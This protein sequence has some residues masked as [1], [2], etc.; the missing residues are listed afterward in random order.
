MRCVPA[1]GPLA[2]F[3]LGAALALATSAAAAPGERRPFPPAGLPTPNAVCYG[4]HR[5]GQRPG[6]AEPTAAQLRQ[7]ARLLRDHWPLLRIYGA[8]GFAPTLLDVLRQEGGRPLVV[9]GVWIAPDDSTANRAEIE[10]AVR[11]AAAY[12][13]L[14]VAVC[15]GNETQVS[16]SAHRCEPAVL[17]AALREVRARVAV[18]VT[19]ADDF[20]FWNKPESAA[21]AAEI[22]FILLHAHPLWNGRQCDEALPWLQ[23]QLADAQARHAGVPVFIGETGWATRRHTEGEQ[24]TLMKGVLGEPEQARFHA[25][26]R[27]WA[28]SVGVTTFCFEAFD[29]NWKGGAHPDEVEK[30]WGLWRSDRSPKLAAPAA[31]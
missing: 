17:L 10:A 15:V 12:P 8:G 31:E 11:L 24:A 6:A 5:D 30:H 18:P 3:A 16:W 21:V 9:L 19:T 29:E 7:D 27:A 25:E 20:N 4:P 2:A 14:V 1:L 28:D 13:D 26:L 22:D 23:A